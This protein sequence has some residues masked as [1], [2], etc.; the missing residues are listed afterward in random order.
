MK[1]LGETSQVICETNELD[2]QSEVLFGQHLLSDAVF[3]KFFWSWNIFNLV[4]T[5]EHIRVRSVVPHLSDKCQ[6]QDLLVTKWKVL[7]KSPIPTVSSTMI[8]YAEFKFNTYIYIYIYPHQRMPT[9]ILRNT[10]V[11]QPTENSLG[12]NNLMHEMVWF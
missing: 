8:K 4:Q 9:Y 5:Y 11:L 12:N 7:I 3:P 2:H 1:S 6:Q 10:S